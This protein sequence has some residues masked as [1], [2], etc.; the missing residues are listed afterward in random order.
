M[1]KIPIAGREIPDYVF[2]LD[3]IVS[4]PGKEASGR[5]QNECEQANEVSQNSG[6]RWLLRWQDVVSN[7]EEEA[8]SA[9]KLYTAKRTSV[10]LNFNIE[11]AL[12]RNF[13][14]HI[15]NCTSLHCREYFPE[16]QAT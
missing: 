8:G 15:Q 5:Y 6:Q 14:C 4:R 12:D 7:N 13:G 9:E 2:R 11:I 10:N 1:D 16:T 3:V